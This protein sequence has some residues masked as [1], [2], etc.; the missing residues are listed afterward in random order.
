MNN[1]KLYDKTI[2]TLKSINNDTDIDMAYRSLLYGKNS[3]LRLTRRGSSKFDPRWIAVIEDTLFELGQ[4]V[5]KP[6][7]ETKQEGE[8][9][10][11][12]LAKKVNAESVQH[13]AS[14][15]QFIKEITD[16]GDVVPSKILSHFN[17]ENLHTYENRFI[18]TFIRRLVLFIEKRYQF[19]TEQ[20]NLTKDEILISKNN[21]IVNGQEV[22]IETKVTIHKDDEDPSIVDAKYYIERIEKVREYVNY[23]YVSPFMKVLKTDK[24]VR[25]P[26]IQTNI[27]RKNPLYR[28]CYETFMFLEK[29]DSLGV[30]YKLEEKFTEFN[31]EEIA[32]LNYIN[33]INYLSIQDT[34]E[35]LVLKEI[36]K[37]YKPK[38]L[39]SIDDEKFVY[40]DLLKGPIEFV[41]TD[42]K[43]RD[44]LAHKVKKD[45]PSHPHKKEKEFFKEDYENNKEYRTELDQ[46]NALLRRKEKEIADYEKYIL[47]LIEARD[48]EEAKEEK[49]R[50]AR[51]MK[52]EMELLEKKRALI[53]KAANDFK[54]EINAKPQKN[55]EKK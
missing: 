13:L 17:T 11:V 21:S 47:K 43:Y 51:I 48:I 41:R 29:F 24:D 31:D 36:E 16:E 55:K 45:L 44:Y 9:T 39:A 50:L 14:H 18:A 23:F 27:I 12:E 26:I 22:E 3:Y 40:D 7:E 4:I 19:I 53:M 6:R 30:S 1:K 8:I 42:E 54:E 46:I 20:I 2:D 32:S 52:E 37:Q 15:T 25:R 10:P 33:L 38:F 35:Y 5:M 34:D 49:A 28:K